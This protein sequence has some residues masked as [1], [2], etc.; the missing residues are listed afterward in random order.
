MQT[1]RVAVNDKSLSHEVMTDADVY[2]LTDDVSCDTV[3]TS[4]RHLSSS[5]D[6]LSCLPLQPPSASDG[7]GR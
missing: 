6:S 7:I 2:E 4:L 1:G 5:T 3:M